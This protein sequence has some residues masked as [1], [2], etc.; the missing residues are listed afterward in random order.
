MAGDLAPCR[1][2]NSSIVLSR[3]YGNAIDFN[4]YKV[5]ACF[6]RSQLGPIFSNISHKLML[7]VLNELKALSQVSDHAKI[8]VVISSFS[9]LGMTLES[10]Q[11]H[12]SKLAYH[13][14]HDTPSEAFAAL[15]G[16]NEPIARE[17][18]IK[19][20]DCIHNAVDSPREYLYGRAE[21][22]TAGYHDMTAFFDRLL[23]R[24]YLL[25]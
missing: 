24:M 14:P 16:G 18:A 13:S 25:D 8:P 20:M 21:L 22:D 6:V 19:F 15:Q 3:C 12:V 5:T 10:L 7:S 17:F 23:A 4:E 9:V 11:Y 2:V 1:D